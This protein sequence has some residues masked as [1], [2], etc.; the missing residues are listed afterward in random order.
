MRGSGRESALG[1]DYR[2]SPRAGR[3]GSPWGV[4]RGRRV[5]GTSCATLRSAGHSG[6]QKEE[7]CAPRNRACFS[8]AP[9]GQLLWEGWGEVAE[10]QRRQIPAGVR[11]GCG[12]LTPPPPPQVPVLGQ[13]PGATELIARQVLFP[14]VGKHLLLRGASMHL[15][16]S[17]PTIKPHSPPPV[18]SHTWPYRLRLTRGHCG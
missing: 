5:A 1:R 2:P 6:G 10:S 13:K 14:E 11:T 9:Q 16:K 12:H 7:L 17:E 18:W 8:C 3:V 15:E 4:L